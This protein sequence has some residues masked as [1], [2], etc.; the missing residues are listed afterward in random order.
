MVCVVSHCLSILMTTGM[1]Q[2]EAIKMHPGTLK[3]FIANLPIT[4][5]VFSIDKL[6]PMR[7]L[8]C[9]PFPF[10]YAQTCDDHA[11]ARHALRGVPMGTHLVSGSSGP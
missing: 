11:L 5:T 9:I 10:P 4:M 2:F 3:V 6:R 8:S 1:P 7:P